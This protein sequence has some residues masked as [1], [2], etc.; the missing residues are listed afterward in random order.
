MIT[1]KELV[2]LNRRG[3]LS[4]MLV[5]KFNGVRHDPLGKGDFDLVISFESKAKTPTK[6][7]IKEALSEYAAK[8]GCE[9]KFDSMS[10]RDMVL[11]AI[12]SLS[13]GHGIVS[14]TI[15]TFYPQVSGEEARF[16]RLTTVAMASTR[17]R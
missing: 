15:S 13:D 5:E 16:M 2:E 6:E 8:L 14:V 17:V 1:A 11:A 12:T 10:G 7:A 4:K 9:L 3:D